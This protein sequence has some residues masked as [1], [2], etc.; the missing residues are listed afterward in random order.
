MIDREAGRA[1]SADGKTLITPTAT[2]GACADLDAAPN[3]DVTP[4]STEGCV[5]C[6]REGTK[7]VHLRLCLTCGNVGCCDSSMRK[8]A[9]LHFHYT[10]HPVMRSHEPGEAWRW[11]F[12]HEVLG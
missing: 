5:D 12:V 7:W 10:L 8:H 2:A 9:T 11:C 1:E 4:N 3:R 6:L